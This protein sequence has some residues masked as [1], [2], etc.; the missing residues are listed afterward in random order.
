[1]ERDRCSLPGP[2]SFPTSHPVPLADYQTLRIG[3][4]AFAVVLF[5]VGI[6]LI[7]SKFLC[8]FVQKSNVCTIEQ[9][10]NSV[11]RAW[12]F[13]FLEEEGA[14]LFSLLSPGPN[15]LLSKE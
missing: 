1:M 10:E 3:G 11:K 15:I 6:L 12:P 5:S 2:S 14:C 4:L 8:S 9:V 7:L 13:P